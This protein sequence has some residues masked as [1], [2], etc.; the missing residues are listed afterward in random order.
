MHY[1]LL[2]FS[3]FSLDL[4]I[5]PSA[6]YHKLAKLLHPVNPPKPQILCGSGNYPGGGTLRADRFFHYFRDGNNIYF[7]LALATEESDDAAPPRVRSSR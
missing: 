1:T 3:W 6:R 5:S 2:Y 7:A 4:A